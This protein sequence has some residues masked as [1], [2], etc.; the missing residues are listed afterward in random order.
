MNAWWHDPLLAWADI[1]EAAVA[2]ERYAAPPARRRVGDWWRRGRAWCVHLDEVHFAVVEPPD[3]DRRLRAALSWTLRALAE[4]EG[5]GWRERVRAWLAELV[6]LPDEALLRR[7]AEG[8]APTEP[9][10]GDGP[11]PGRFV[12]LHIGP[13]G[14]A[15]PASR[16][17]LAAA[18]REVAL[19]QRS[20]AWL[21]WVPGGTGGQGRH[22]RRG[23]Q[24]ADGA[25]AALLF[26][27]L[28]DVEDAR[29]MD[30]LTAFIETLAAEAFAACAAFVGAPV[31]QPQDAYLGLA[32]AVAAWRSRLWTEGA[33]KVVVWG[34]NPVAHLL[35]AI[36]APV[37]RLFLDMVRAQA[38]GGDVRLAP[39]LA[40]ALRGLIAANLNV[41]E[42]ARLLYLHRNT[43]MNRIERIR[44][45]TGYDIRDFDAALA[46]WLATLLAGEETEAGGL[47]SGSGASATCLRRM[48]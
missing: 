35:Q 40:E 47:G 30:G 2:V 29:V 8:H 24:P 28:D 10:P 36:P 4:A 39:E 15:E 32:T 42:A 21:G 48:R 19:A 41:S 43:L 23:G 27:P 26:W 17:E 14:A 13:A 25:Q 16:A 3:L 1:A 6:N 34:E 31:L 18:V 38:P 45:Q 46:L 12:V 20:H 11:G 7:I 33:R 37:V 9:M 5:R 44:A 22:A